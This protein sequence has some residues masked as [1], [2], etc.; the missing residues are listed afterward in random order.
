MIFRHHYPAEPLSN[1]VMMLWFVA[2]E[3]PYRREKILPTGTVELIINLASPYRVA[4]GGSPQRRSD[5]RH[6]WVAGFQS[7]FLVNEASDAWVSTI[8]ASFKPGGAYPIFGFP[9]SELNDQVVELDL[10]WGLEAGRMRD[11]ILSAGDLPAMFRAFERV[12]LERLEPDVFEFEWV[13]FAADIL[14]GA[15]RIPSIY[16]LS[17]QIGISQ[18]HLIH[19][20]KKLVGVT[21]KTLARILRFRQALPAI[22]NSAPISWAELALRC[23]YYDQAHFNRDFQAFCGLN[24]TEYHQLRSRFLG[25]T[26]GPQNAGFIPLG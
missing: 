9:I 14:S 25:D 13:S 15:E 24:P 5:S 18:K 20:F 17:R 2:G 7:G 26:A 22:A 19:Q 11:Q 23:G 10:V 1:Y 12:L 8:G 4:P 16:D 21:P 3:M 6:I